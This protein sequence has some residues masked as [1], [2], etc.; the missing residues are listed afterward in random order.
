[1][2]RWIQFKILESLEYACKGQLPSSP[3]FRSTIFVARCNLC[4]DNPENLRKTRRQMLPRLKRSRKWLIE[5]MKNYGNHLGRN[6][7]GTE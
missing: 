3:P 6:L 7:K 4:G 1:M 5:T 2:L